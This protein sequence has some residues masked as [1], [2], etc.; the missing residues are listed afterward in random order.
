MLNQPNLFVCLSVYLCVLVECVSE[1]GDGELKY[2]VAIAE[3]RYITGYL[4]VCLSVS[5]CL[6]ARLSVCLSVCLSMCL[7]LSLCLCVCLCVLV[8]CVSEHAVGELRYIVAI[9]ESRCITGPLGIAAA[10]T[11]NNMVSN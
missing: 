2:F 1:H 3:S 8:E 5:I 11:T 7:Y 9:A 4:S 10:A 6:S